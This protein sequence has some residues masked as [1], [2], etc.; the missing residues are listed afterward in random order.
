MLVVLVVV[1][2]VVVVLVV[3]VA[4]AAAALA[5]AMFYLRLSILRI[6]GRSNSLS[7]APLVKT[8]YT[9][10]APTAQHERCRRKHSHSVESACQLDS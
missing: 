6:L 7:A 1:V 5:S 4:A 9:P 2:V 3:V 10:P 8:S